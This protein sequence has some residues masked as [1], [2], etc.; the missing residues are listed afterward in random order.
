MSDAFSKPTPPSP[1]DVIHP[2]EKDASS[3]SEDV[4]VSSKAQET[5]ESLEIGEK[6]EDVISSKSLNV[7]GK[8]ENVLKT[9]IPLEP[10]PKWPNWSLDYLRAVIECRTDG[11]AARK[12]GLSYQT[13]YEARLSQADFA[14]A[15]DACRKYR[16]SLIVSDLEDVTLSRA[17]VSDPNDRMSATLALAHL[18]AR[19]DKYKDKQAGHAPVINITLGYQIPVT[20]R[21]AG[22]I[23]DAEYSE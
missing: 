10:K 22:P 16:D 6:G 1:I 8:E 18:K 23:T 15:W 5:T 3:I 9:L 20:K 11:A 2:S 12:I 17:L 7:A 14:A 21:Q 4:V 13:V 19:D